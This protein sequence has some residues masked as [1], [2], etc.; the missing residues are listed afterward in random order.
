MA[1]NTSKSDGATTGQADL[2]NYEPVK[3]RV[4]NDGLK[5]LVSDHPD[6]AGMPGFP[7]SSDPVGYNVEDKYNSL[8][9]LSTGTAPFQKVTILDDNGEIF[10]GSG[11][12]IGGFAFSDDGGL[13]E[14]SST[15]STT[16]FK[17]GVS[18]DSSSVIISHGFSGIIYAYD[19]NSKIQLSSK[20]AGSEYIFSSC[21][22]KELLEFYAMNT[23]GYIYSSDNPITSNWIAEGY[24]A[25]LPILSS[26]T[27]SK[28]KSGYVINQEKNIYF[29]DDL[30]TGTATLKFTAVGGKLHSI[31]TSESD[32]DVGVVFVGN[33]GL[34]SAHVTVDGGETY[35]QATAT[36]LTQANIVDSIKVTDDI[37]VIIDSDNKFN[38]TF[39]FCE[40]FESIE[41]GSLIALDVLYKTDNLSVISTTKNSKE[42]YKITPVPGENP[43]FTS[44]KIDS[45]NE[46][47]SYW[48]KD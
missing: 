17:F 6:L 36:G 39:D 40:T 8:L 45:P 20:S 4:K 9:Q 21:Y 12:N 1:Y 33:T 41:T 25:G 15:E 37:Y 29:V 3:G 13:T 32:S 35:T 44:K 31:K 2:F 23:K 46:N 28:T 30:T 38:I 5:R 18:T 22:N 43:E 19:Y 48:T 47:F 7:I 14:K 11:S 34:N 26:T 42:R 16:V 24:I 27:F 10:I